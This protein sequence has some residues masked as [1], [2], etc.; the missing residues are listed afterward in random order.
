MDLI[1]NGTV[2]GSIPYDGTVQ[3]TTISNIDISGSVTV[4]I[5][6]TNSSSDRVIIEPF[7]QE[8]IL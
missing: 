2:V 4:E 5:D 3:T 6:A 7:Q 8:T 1:V